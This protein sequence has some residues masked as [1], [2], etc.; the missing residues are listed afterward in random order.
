M[1]NLPSSNSL[2]HWMAVG[3][4][5]IGTATAGQ[6]QTI[7]RIVGANG[8]VTFSDKPPLS[9]DQSKVA[10]TGA[11]SS[12]SASDVTLPF[13]LRQVVGKYPV[14]LYTAPSC[15]PCDRGR[16]LLAGRGVP[17]TE[18]TI[19]SAEDI[20]SLQRMNGDSSLPALTIGAQRLKGMSETEWTQYLDAAGYPKTSQLPAAYKGA[21]AA[22]LVSVAK[23]T[24]TEPKPV[25][26]APQAELPARGPTPSNP[27]GIQF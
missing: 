25:S 14:T 19:T 2:L 18:R 11:G 9:S 1:K 24:K 3:A 15:A 10:T 6:T 5:L 13:E 27:T 7:Y 21:P 8:K 26:P 17:F 23:A 22:P 20:A 16:S 4:F 12:G